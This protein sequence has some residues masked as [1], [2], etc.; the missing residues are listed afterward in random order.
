[1]NSLAYSFSEGSALRCVK[2]C[3]LLEEDDEQIRM[4]YQVSCM[5]DDVGLL[6]YVNDSFASIL[7]GARLFVFDRYSY[8]FDRHFEVINE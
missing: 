5:P 2:Q 1:M 4:P 3:L 6:I 7:M 8:E